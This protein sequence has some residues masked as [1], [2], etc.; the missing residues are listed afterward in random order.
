MSEPPKQCAFVP[1]QSVRTVVGLSW[2]TI[3]FHVRKQRLGTVW[4]IDRIRLVRRDAAEAFVRERRPLDG[5]EALT[6]LTTLTPEPAGDA[7]REE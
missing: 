4:R 7:S 6:A 2:P 5:V 3:D 1:L